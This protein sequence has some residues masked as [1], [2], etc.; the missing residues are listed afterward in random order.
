MTM[1]RGPVSRTGQEPEPEPGAAAPDA[2]GDSVHPLCRATACVRRHLPR[3]PGAD[4]GPAPAAAVVRP[5]LLLLRAPLRSAFGA[6]AVTG[7]VL[8][9]LPATLPG[10]RPLGASWPSAVPAPGDAAVV[11]FPAAAAGWPW[12][13]GP[14]VRRQGVSAGGVPAERT[15]TRAG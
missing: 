8:S 6:G 11:V 14:L 4:R 12:G 10:P 7:P 9:P 15:L 13:D 5:A 3:G 1:S 2:P